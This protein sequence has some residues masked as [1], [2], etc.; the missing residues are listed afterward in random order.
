LPAIS[1]VRLRDV[2]DIAAASLVPYNEA[3]A[4]RANTRSFFANA[5]LP[6]VPAEQGGAPVCHCCGNLFEE[7]GK[8]KISA[9]GFKCALCVRVDQAVYRKTGS[10]TRIDIN[11]CMYIQTFIS[12]I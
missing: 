8:A 1:Q 9:K 6:V 2:Q 4:A 7:F 10:R 11:R 5:P 3:E 12:S